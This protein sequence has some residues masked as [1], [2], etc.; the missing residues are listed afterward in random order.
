M[1]ASSEAAIF[2]FMYVTRLPV[3]A[4]VAAQVEK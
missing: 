1:A 3:H 2:L 4:V